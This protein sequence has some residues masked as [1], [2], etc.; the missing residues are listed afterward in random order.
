M[1]NT[2]KIGMMNTEKIGMMN[3]EKTRIV[4]NGTKQKAIFT[5]FSEIL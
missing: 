2:E 3:T 5:D 1:L 4:N